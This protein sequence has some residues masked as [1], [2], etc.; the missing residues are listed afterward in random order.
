V[1]VVVKSQEAER[2]VISANISL[3]CVNC[4]VQTG[5]IVLVPAQGPPMQLAHEVKY[6]HYESWLSDRTL[7]HSLAQGA[8]LDHRPFTDSTYHGLRNV[9]TFRGRNP[10]K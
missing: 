6:Y 10:Q 1:M 2:P 8:T 4:L 7:I 3:C 9:G 5:T